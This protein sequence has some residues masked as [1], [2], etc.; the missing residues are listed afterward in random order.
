MS[1]DA[2][3]LASTADGREWLS[4]AGISIDGASSS[5]K[6]DLMMAGGGTDSNGAGGGVSSA[7]A[8]VS[9]SSSCALAAAAA[10]AAAGKPHR[11]LASARAAADR[12]M[13]SCVR[14]DGGHHSY[15]SRPPL[16]SFSLRFEDPAVESDYRRTAWRPGRFVRG[17]DGE[18]EDDP[19]H[20][21]LA[22]NAFNAYFDV[23]V[24]GY[25]RWTYTSTYGNNSGL[26]ISPK[27][28]VSVPVSV[29]FVIAL[30]FPLIV[31]IVFFVTSLALI[32]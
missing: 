23:L 17:G 5:S 19:Q 11:D 13:I 32:V 16:R 6:K 25:E 26:E 15:F 30:A 29:T 24:S 20:R 18:D 4:G 21:T 14:E 27:S 7:H 22:S 28:S 2:G 10:A 3:V 1:F 8:Q 9:S 12:A 31:Q